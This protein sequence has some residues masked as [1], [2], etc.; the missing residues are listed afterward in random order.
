MKKRITR[1]KIKN[2]YEDKFVDKGENLQ[3]LRDRPFGFLGNLVVVVPATKSQKQE[4]SH[5]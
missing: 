1:E 2:R 5:Q 3:L 4:I